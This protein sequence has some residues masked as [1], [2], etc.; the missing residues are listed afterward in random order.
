MR[1]VL[2]NNE[3]N[4]LCVWLSDLSDKSSTGLFRFPILNTCAFLFK[5]DKLPNGH[6]SY[7]SY[8]VYVMFLVQFW[9]SNNYHWYLKQSL[10]FL[11]SDPQPVCLAWDE[12]EPTVLHCIMDDKIYTRRTYGWT[13]HA[14]IFTT[15]DH[16][17]AVTNGCECHNIFLIEF[18]V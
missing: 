2:W 14:N 7:F 17:V 8:P 15:S 4:I 13:T 16:E 1:Q 3:S 12:I 18:V 10:R 5:R 11:A 6:I 9:T